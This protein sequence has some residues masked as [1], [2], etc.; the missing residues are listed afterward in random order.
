M[1]RI[2]IDS[3]EATL[4]VIEENKGEFSKMFLLFTG[5][6]GEDGSSWCPDC[7]SS[8]PVVHK[9]LEEFESEFPV[10][11]IKSLFVTVYVGVRDEYVTND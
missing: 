10:E 1:K 6:K 11:A 7:V 9:T 3:H 4:K 5:S 2:Q 8:E